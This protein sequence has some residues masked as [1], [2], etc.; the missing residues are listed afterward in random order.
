ML[1][2]FLTVL[3]DNLSFTRDRS[4]INHEADEKQ[5]T[6]AATTGFAAEIFLLPLAPRSKR[7]TGSMAQ[8]TNYP[9]KDMGA[10]CSR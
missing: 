10:N 3:P 6:N 7:A 4:F 9:T 1:P 8:A 5:E 2:Q